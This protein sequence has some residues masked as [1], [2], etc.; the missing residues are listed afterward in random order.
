M[1]ELLRETELQHG[2]RGIGKSGVTPSNP[3]PTLAE[4]GLTKRD[5]AEAHRWRGRDLRSKG[6]ERGSVKWL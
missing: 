4:L 3:T 6:G 1:G 5:S 2:T